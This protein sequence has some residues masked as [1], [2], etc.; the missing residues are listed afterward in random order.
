MILA[1]I[2]MGADS[3]QWVL[4]DTA[5]LFPMMQNAS[6]QYPGAISG[7]VH[8]LFYLIPKVSVLAR[9]WRDGLRYGLDIEDLASQYMRLHTTI[10]TWQPTSTDEVHVLCGRLYQQALLVYL[11]SSFEHEEE[12]LE[13]G[14]AYSAPVHQAFNDFM[15][16]LGSIPLD[17]S[18]STTLCWPLAIF[19][20]CARSAEHRNTIAR[21]LDSLSETYAAQSVRDTKK[22]LELMWEEDNPR[23]ANP[24]GFEDMMNR[25]KMTVLFL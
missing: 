22:L 10:A 11:A 25:A 4:N 8:E 9:E 23:A 24:L 18:I 1:H 6:N 21:R 7:C 20:S 12:V 13:Q 5:L 17:S 3:D 2:T 19:G 16:F 14:H 15:E